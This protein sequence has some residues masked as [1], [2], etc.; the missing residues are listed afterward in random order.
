MSRGMQAAYV[1]MCV[2]VGGCHLLQQGLVCSL[3]CQLLLAKEEGVGNHVVYADCCWHTKTTAVCCLPI[4][5]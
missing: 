1:C 4:W 5:P 2:C 3:G